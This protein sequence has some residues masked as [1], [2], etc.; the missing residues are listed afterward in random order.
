MNSDRNRT[1]GQIVDH[2][3][4]ALRATAIPAGPP[5]E[6]VDAVTAAGESAL[7]TYHVVRMSL[8]P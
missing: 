7:L 3:V 4:E 5:K 2:A 6:A 8:K 1:D